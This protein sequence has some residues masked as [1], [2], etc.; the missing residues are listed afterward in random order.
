[1]S[2]ITRNNFLERALACHRWSQYLKEPLLATRLR[3]FHTLHTAELARH[4][5]DLAEGMTGFLLPGEGPV[6]EKQAQAYLEGFMAILEM[7]A[8][9]EMPA[10]DL[11]ERHLQ[12]SAA[13]GNQPD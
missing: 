2:E 12:L 7:P 4:N 13:L 9:M 11:F 8:A 6:A 3:K 1:M 5:A 10:A